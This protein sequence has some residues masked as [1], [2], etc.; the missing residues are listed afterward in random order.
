MHTNIS[1][2]IKTVKSVQ[3]HNYGHMENQEMEMEMEMDMEKLKGKILH[4]SI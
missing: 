2:I 1:H 4:G 3:L